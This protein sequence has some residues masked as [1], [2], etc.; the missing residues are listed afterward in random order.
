MNTH[1]EYK[2]FEMPTEDR[3][4]V[5]LSWLREGGELVGVHSKGKGQRKPL[6]VAIVRRER[7]AP[8]DLRR[9]APAAA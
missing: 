5:F 4:R 2:E 1:W 3:D 7:P 9:P 6:P 8:P